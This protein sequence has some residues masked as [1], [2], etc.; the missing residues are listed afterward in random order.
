M[1]KLVDEPDFAQELGTRARKF[2]E[3][4]FSPLAVGQKIKSRL[5][6]IN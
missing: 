2:I 3:T 6:E 4:E 5:A 1:R